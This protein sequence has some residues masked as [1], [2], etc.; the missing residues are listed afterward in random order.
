MS[1]LG[2]IKLKDLWIL[3]VVTSWVFLGGRRGW[4]W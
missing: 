4:V 3:L 1:E 2:F